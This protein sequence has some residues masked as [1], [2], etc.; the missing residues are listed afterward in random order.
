MAQADAANELRGQW[1]KAQHVGPSSVPQAIGQRVT[2]PVEPQ[3]M[4]DESFQ[5]NIVNDKS[6]IFHDG[7]GELGVTNRKPS[8]FSQ[9]LDFQK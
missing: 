6:S 4:A 5:R 9:E 2:G 7:A 3:G 1:Y 8:N